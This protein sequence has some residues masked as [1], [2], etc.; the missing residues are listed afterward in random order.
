L[1]RP[2]PDLLL[3]EWKQA[4][5]ESAT[6]RLKIFLGMCPGVGKTYAMLEAAHR[7]R[8]EG[9]DVIIGIA[10]T[11]GRP[12]T[13]RLL[14]GLELLRRRCIHYRGIT[15]SEFDLDGALARKPRV[16]LVDELAHANAAG[17]RHDKRYQDVL[18]LLDAGISVF[19][20][21]NVQHIESLV[22]HV[23]QITGVLVRE[24]VPDSV[25]DDADDIELIDLPPE[26]LRKRLA[27]S[28]VYRGD[29][30]EFAAE[31]FFRE[32]NLT[33]LR[34]LALRYT[35]DHVD[36]DLRTVMR[37]KRIA[38]PWRTRE[39]FL[40]GVGPS[41]FSESL[42]RWT[43]SAARRS[44]CP[45]VAVHIDSGVELSAP[46]KERLTRNLS[47][48]RMLGAEVV[49]AFGADVADVLLRAARDHHATNIVV[50][51]PLS[52]L[53]SRI[54]GRSLADRLIAGRHGIDISVVC[55]ASRMDGE[56]DA[57]VLRWRP[58][59][60][61]TGEVQ[62][63]IGAVA[64][65]TLVGFWVEP[66][67]GYW[68]VALIYLLVIVILG[69]FLGPLVIIGTALLGALLWN[70]CFIP[71]IWSFSIS[72]TEDA[73][74][75]GTFI[76]VALAM[77][78]LT[79]RLRRSQIAEAKREK[80]TATLLRFFE[81]TMRQPTLAD[82]LQVAIRQMDSIFAA[83][84]V[85]FDV[86]AGRTLVDPPF[87][88]GTFSPDAKEIAVAE[89]C[90]ANRR[91]AGSQTGTLAQAQALYIPLLHLD[92]VFGV[93]GIRREAPLAVD[94]RVLLDAIAS[95]IALLLAKQHFVE[96]ARHAELAEQSNHLQRTLLDCVSHELK[97]P[98]TVLQTAHDALA[99]QHGRWSAEAFLQLFE[100]IGIATR[101]L[102]RVVDN[103]LEI[104][105]LEAGVVKP[106]A[107]WCDLADLLET[108]VESSRED[109]GSRFVQI[110]L[111]ET[112]LPLI[113]TDPTLL[114]HALHNLLVNAAA[115]GPPDTPIELA[116]AVGGGRLVITVAD[117]GPGFPDDEI[118]KLF[119]KFFRGA[120]AK[121]GGTGLG[122]SIVKSLARA[123]SG[124]VRASNRP[125]PPGAIFTLEL[126][127]STAA[128]PPEE[129][130]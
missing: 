24:T 10:E 72:K 102:R 118:P 125:D 84:S 56:N 19:T 48:A 46:E 111:G 82:T 120:H 88:G 5:A 29:A 25:L 79:S 73:M 12:E 61:L 67:I 16:I 81:E 64:L 57:G 100:E 41:P 35:A 60:G 27:E 26:E 113:R 128:A 28:R 71:P 108:A 33:A 13:A 30:K 34:Q 124:S 53:W 130:P 55:S 99:R 80:R 65:V 63:G 114:Q 39:R 59:P 123:L 18:E 36:Q 117:R 105:Q 77:G 75:F 101:R 1:S 17:S 22:D 21:L 121:P 119:T 76:F 50:G 52:S 86:T 8:A 94:E 66:W 109:L 115:Y 89:W 44:N 15:L 74:M 58:A 20:T 68:S 127:V 54:M 2:D 42:I 32:E 51:R 9:I 69:L 14:E 98:L 7:L 3:A 23:R 93:L 87:P 104:T 122:L 47:L 90:C 40:V 103:L 92:R 6:G 85:V 43:R 78:S 70:F 91:S 31:N 107:E 97:T 11:H 129:A 112:P 96:A 95:Q 116:G 62:A 45:W 37:A 106:S 126:A 83:T 38:G 4:E 110:R 49:L